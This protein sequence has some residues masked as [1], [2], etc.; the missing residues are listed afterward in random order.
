M[1]LMEGFVTYLSANGEL[2]AMISDRLYPLR[3]PESPTLPAVVYQ[4]ISCVPTY[5]QDGYSE[6]EQTRMQLTCW[7]TTLLEA[8]QIR[9]I[10]KRALGG[11]R[12]VMGSEEVGAVFIEAGRSDIDGETGLS[13]ARIDVM[14][15]HKD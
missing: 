5:S 3:L 2:T 14:I 11:F 8:L 7:S 4:E 1:M 10:L 9:Q 15:W 13:Y 6:V 12:G